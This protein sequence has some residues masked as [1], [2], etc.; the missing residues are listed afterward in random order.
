[1][2]GM[3]CGA[4]VVASLSSIS[5]ASAQS[6]WRCG[7]IGHL[8]GY[9]V[10]LGGLTINN[11]MLREANGFLSGQPYVELSMSAVN[12]GGDSAYLSVQFFAVDEKGAAVMAMSAAP[13]FD[14]VGAGRSDEIKESVNVNSGE[15]AMVRQ[16]C[17]RFDGKFPP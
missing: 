16:F 12:R 15:L 8:G 6:P 13:I 5:P 7:E 17:L 14:M 11:F 2:C 10:E 3:V 4:A 1:M 9:V